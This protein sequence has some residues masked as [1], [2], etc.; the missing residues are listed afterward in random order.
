MH[1][2]PPQHMFS[3]TQTHLRIVALNSC[4]CLF[5]APRCP[6]DQI[7]YKALTQLMLPCKGESHLLTDVQ[8]SAGEMALQGKVFAAKS[9]DLA[10]FP[11]RRNDPAPESCLLPA[12]YV[13]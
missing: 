9:D 7:N 3:T 4:I 13:L 2:A 11:T 12:I 6:T 10:S 5:P 1:T 8:I